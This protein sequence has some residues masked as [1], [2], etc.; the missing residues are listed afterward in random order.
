MKGKAKPARAFFLQGVDKERVAV[1][2]IEHFLLGVAATEGSLAL[3][4]EQA[5]AALVLGV[6]GEA[7]HEAHDHG[8]ADHGQAHAEARR[9]LGRLRRQV[10]VRARDAAQVAAGHEQRHADGSLG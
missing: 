4:L 1:P 2:E 7:Q 3:S 8:A 10:D 6:V 9:V 5:P